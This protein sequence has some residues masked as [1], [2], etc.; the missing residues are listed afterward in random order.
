[1]F[2]CFTIK[3]DTITKINHLLQISEYQHYNEIARWIASEVREELNPD[4]LLKLRAWID[5]CPENRRLYSNIK[6][7]TNFN[8]RNTKLQEIDTQG[9]WNEFALRIEKKMKIVA[10]KKV[11]NYAAAII[12]PLILV[13]GIYYY[14]TILAIQKNSLAQVNLIQPGSTKAILVLNSGESML[15]DSVNA[16]S[17][18]EK[19]GT[20]INKSKGE[21]NYTNQSKKASILPIFNTINIPRGGEFNLVLADGTRVF[22]NAM[23]S[24]KYP[25]TFT[26]NTREVE[27]SGEAYFEVKKDVERP[28]IVKTTAINIEVLGTSFNLNA[29]VNTEKIVTT[30]VE[31]SVKLISHSNSE[32]MFLEPEE[33]ATFHI[34]D[35]L[36]E[37]ERVDVNLYTAWKDGNF[38]FHD[39]RLE[40]IMN[41]L[42]RWYT[43]NVIYMNESVKELRF[44][45][46][47]N[48][49]GDINQILDIIGTTKKINIEINQNTIFFS[50]KK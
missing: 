38:I 48:R 6:K 31:G 14:S 11:F 39:A 40:D 12:L 7:S 44:S 49:Y 23:S 29:Y 20:L 19:D 35:G 9:G 10:I 45:G 5:E 47:L 26:G 50:R 17:I 28:F 21:L 18:T 25:V 37:I 24:F 43:A 32:S 33:Q 13:G 4:D 16:L 8:D 42:T 30:L 41:T 36:T 15:L 3:S 34:K 22:L 27:L 46:N 2:T 1:M